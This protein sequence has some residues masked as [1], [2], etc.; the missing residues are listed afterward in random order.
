MIKNLE[1]ELGVT[2]FERS[3][4]K[5]TLTDAGRVIFEQAQIIENAFS[6]LEMELDALKGLKNGH[7]RIGLPPIMDSHFIS[8]LIGNFHEQYPDITFQLVE[9]GSK[10]IEEDVGSGQLDVGVV[11]LPTND[12]L[13]DH[14]SFLKESLKLIVH[15]THPLADRKEV[16]LAELH[17][18]AFIL[19]NNDFVLHE[20]IISSCNSVGFKPRIISG[21]SQ[22]DF[23]EEMVA[24]KLG[25]TL[26]PESICHH[27]HKGVRSIEVVNPS[28]N[29]HLAIIW[30]KDHYLSY[31]AKEW[32]QF[33]K[34]Q[35][36][37]KDK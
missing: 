36:K 34:E 19:F 29:W 7:L 14:F 17:D 33:T 23:L 18:E 37:G 20:R 2:L 5:L 16:N 9:D 13:F 25:I 22:W 3:R 30:R 11:V 15:P 31:A 1:T 8:D 12:T 10:K 32:L 6:N 28:I 35:I 21:S 26:L 24:S 4:K 27:L